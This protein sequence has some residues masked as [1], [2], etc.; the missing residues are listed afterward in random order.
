MTIEN[1]AD[2]QLNGTN[3]WEEIKKS[4]HTISMAIKI[5][6]MMQIKIHNQRTENIKNTINT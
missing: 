2:I 5:N 3:Y 4:L 1:R 6:E